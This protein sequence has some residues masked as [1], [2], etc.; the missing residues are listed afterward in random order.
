[1]NNI[2]ISK[3]INT[4][5]FDAG[6]V[7]FSRKLSNKGYRK[8]LEDYLK[9]KGYNNKNIELALKNA[10]KFSKK[11]L[12]LNTLTTLEEEKI[13]KYKYL[14]VLAQSLSEEDDELIDDIM[15]NIFD[16]N[17]YKLYDE[18][19]YVLDECKKRN[20]KLGVISNAKPSILLVFDNLDIRKYFDVIIISSIV[21]EEKPY[22]EI[23]LKALK[24]INSK[25]EECLFIDD[26]KRNVEGAIRCGMKAVRLDRKKQ[27]LKTLLQI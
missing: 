3:E 8:K 15:N 21:R 18:V 1:M 13:Y 25:A 16:L 11:H 12:L 5:F 26:N 17:I 9:S 6:N 20:Y 24:E 19:I 4:I 23:Y 14:K 27:D 7:L 10:K 22:E 2:L